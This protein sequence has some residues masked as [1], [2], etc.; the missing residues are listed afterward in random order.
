MELI[1]YTTTTTDLVGAVPVSGWDS[2]MWV[3]RYRD[4]GE[5]EIKARLSSG[6]LEFLPLGTFVTHVDTYEVM[7][8]EDHFI[9][10]EIDEDPLIKITGRSMEVI[11]EQRVI[12]CANDW[13]TYWQLYFEYTL[14]S[15]DI[16]SQA[17]TMIQDHT[18]TGIVDNAGDAFPNILADKT[19]GLTGTITTARAMKRQTLHA[20]V[21]DLLAQEDYGIR[22]IRKHPFISPFP[23]TGTN[24]RFRIHKGNDVSKNVRFGTD[25]GEIEAAEYLNSL[26]SY[27]NVAMV[28]GSVY[29]V[30]VEGDAR[31][32]G[33]DP[34]NLDRRVLLVDGKDIDR[35]YDDTTTTGE[36]D[37]M[38]A[39]MV[40][41]GQEA[42]GKQ[43][44]LEIISVDISKNV[45]YVYREDYDIGDI[46]SVYG[47]HGTS[48]QMRVM[49]FVEIEDEEGTSAYPTL[50]HLP[51]TT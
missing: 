9:E 42:L 36:R 51:Y 38:I 23:G 19:T 11:L 35:D 2:L 7:V 47:N 10:E 17:V 12:G 1:K 26:R 29:E 25:T 27:R 22:V 32:T 48:A 13:S 18:Q 15:A 16:P 20:A 24:S 14:A 34:E 33:P 31:W 43:V 37:A 28:S 44:T 40:A 41:R 30:L 6:L 5:I 39:K 45:D 4:P 46:V 3:E 50:T 8:I 49:E 21:I